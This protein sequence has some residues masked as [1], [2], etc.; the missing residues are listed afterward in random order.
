MIHGEL[1]KEKKQQSRKSGI[2]SLVDSSMQSIAK[3]TG[4]AR[5]STIR[6]SCRNSQ[7]GGSVLSK[8]PIEEAPRTAWDDGNGEIRFPS[9]FQNPDAPD[10]EKI[11]L[12]AV[13]PT[14]VAPTKQKSLVSRSMTN[15]AMSKQRIEHRDRK[16]RNFF[17]Q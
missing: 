10:T 6:Q 9:G 17:V 16:Q 11:N 12:T 13:V 3:I 14:P 7:R 2:Q 1:D 5:S 4:S 15:I 8:T